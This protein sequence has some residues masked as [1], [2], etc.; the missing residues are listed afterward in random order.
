MPV[1]RNNCIFMSYFNIFADSYG[2]EPLSDK[3][4]HDV[5]IRKTA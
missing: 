1:N 3:Q 5:S 4:P 2:K